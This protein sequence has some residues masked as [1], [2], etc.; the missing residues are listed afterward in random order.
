MIKK[1]HEILDSYQMEMVETLQKL[2]MI[3]SVLTEKK[4]DA[5]FGEGIQKSLEFMLEMGKNKGFECINFENF[6][7]ELNLGSGVESIGAVSHLD[8]V[9]EG[10]GW[11]FDPYGGEIINDRIYGR[12]AVDDKGPL[13]AVFYAC[14]AIKDSGLPLSK[15]IK[16]IIGTNEERG[17]FPCIKYYKEHGQVPSCGIVPDSWFPVAYAEKGFLDFQLTRHI[18]ESEECEAEEIR[19]LNLKGGEALNIVAPEAK[20]ELRVSG[21]GKETILNVL[22]DQ[23]LDGRIVI[24]EKVDILT[25]KVIGKAAHASTPEIG[26]NAISKLLCLLEK[27]QFAPAQ[28]CST[29]HRL[30]NMTGKDHDGTGLG[31]ESS[32]HSGDLTNNLGTLTYEDG[33]LCLKMNIRSPITV[34]PES[35][36][37][38]LNAAAR[39]VNMK[40]ELLNYNPH[41]Y[42]PEDHP[43]ICLLKEVYEDVTGDA[44]S[45]PI[46]H[47]GGSYARI[48]E[49]F[50]PFG[51]S[52]RGEEL[53]FHKQDESI[54]I[55]RLLLLSKIYAEAL[56]RLAK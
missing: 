32:D 34:K 33:Y 20:A 46:A 19:L 52:I 16:H 48:L 51:P 37:D 38:K 22:K 43:L 3:K 12:G 7:C 44:D 23:L 1:L 8:V 18:K 13:I 15:K 42:M 27:F 45:K 30:A 11:M 53:C 17:V 54:S 10:T 56:Y 36:E 25:I 2:I 26:M 28:L 6:V 5:P 40:C 35:L 39:E 31:I 55:E 29:I 9:P 50:V 21:Q 24:E 41:F 14:C 4:G 49:N 47:G